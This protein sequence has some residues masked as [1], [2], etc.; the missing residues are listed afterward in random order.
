MMIMSLRRQTSLELRLE[1]GLELSAR[2]RLS[3]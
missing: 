3:R 1:L 2:A